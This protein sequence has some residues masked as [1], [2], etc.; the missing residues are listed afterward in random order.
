[1]S[2][3][4][5]LITPSFERGRI[6]LRHEY[7]RALTDAG[8]VV[9]PAPLEAVHDVASYC[10][11]IRGLVLSGGG[12]VDPV[13]YRQQPHAALGEIDPERDELE[14]SLIAYALQKAI[15]I[16]AICRGMQVLNV[17]MGGTLIQDIPKQRP[18]ALR[19]GQKAPRWHTSHA[20]EVAEGSR[21]REVFSSGFGRVNS[22]HHQ[23]VDRLGN[24][25]RSTAVAPDGIV[26]AIEGTGN[27]FIVGVQWHPEDLYLYEPEARGL[28]QLFAEA[29]RGEQWVQGEPVEVGYREPDSC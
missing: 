28:F 25:L 26:E 20:V 4:P 11:H 17:A 13:R 14:F 18:L 2:K 24:N 8:F 3:L 7:C 1:M 23:A 6:S 15:P 29:C 12:D 10:D 21:L 5:V 27:T 19:H 9:W 22:F 16:L